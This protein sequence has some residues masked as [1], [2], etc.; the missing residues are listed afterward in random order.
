MHHWLP[1]AVPTF[2]SL[3]RI[4]ITFLTLFTVDGKSKHCIL[5][6]ALATFI[7]LREF[8]SLYMC[9]ALKKCCISE[10]VTSSSLWICSAYG[11][12]YIVWHC[13]PLSVN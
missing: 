9:I 6:M 11:C 2:P 7:L 3:K 12:V 10:I 8:H 1:D 5:P 4:Q 13:H